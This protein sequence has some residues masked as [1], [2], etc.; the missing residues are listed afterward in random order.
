[1]KIL[2]KP[3]DI[4]KRSLWRKYVDYAVADK[5]DDELAEML[6]RDEEFEINEEDALVIDLLK[7]LETPHLSY[8]LN[9]LIQDFLNQRSIKNN[10]DNK[11]YVNKRGLLKVI[12]TFEKNFPDYYNCDDQEFKDGIKTLKKYSSKFKERIDS[13][14]ITIIRIHDIQM[15]CVPI[16]T[17]KKMIN[18]FV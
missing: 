17:V 4:V 10:D 18:M 11:Y 15:E 9:R 16:N 12:N 5:S 8:K 7:V 3:S 14:D 2:I 1:M 6:E 13:T